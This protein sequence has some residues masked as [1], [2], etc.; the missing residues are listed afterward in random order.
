MALHLMNEEQ[1]KTLVVISASHT[2][3]IAPRTDIHIVNLQILR[4]L[5]LYKQD[6]VHRMS[7]ILQLAYS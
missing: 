4:L 6:V 1:G 5:L 3:R 2:T 7:D